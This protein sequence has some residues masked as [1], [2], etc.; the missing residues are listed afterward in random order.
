MKNMQHTD[1]LTFNETDD[2]NDS[3]WSVDSILK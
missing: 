1:P 2:T 3:N